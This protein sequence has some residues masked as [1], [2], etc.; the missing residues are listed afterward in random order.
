MLAARKARH[1][2]PG[3]GT[4]GQRGTGESL[5]AGAPILLV[6][7]SPVSLKLMRLLLTYEGFDVRTAE[8]AEDALQMLESFRPALVLTDI[9]M[10]GMDGVEMTRRIKSNRRTSAIRV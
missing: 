6:D 4:A 5:M 10:P 3:L 9:R 8:R 1:D 2:P 7:D